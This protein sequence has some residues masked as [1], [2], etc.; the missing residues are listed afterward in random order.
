MV[1]MSCNQYLMAEGRPAI[2]MILLAGGA[3]LNM[4]LDALFVLVLG[5]GVSG[6]AA[7]TVIAQGTV[8][9]YLLWFYLSGRSALIVSRDA[10]RPRCRWCGR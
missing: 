7:A 4:A 6:A 2:A 3:I 1:A 8:V 9:G 10:L 5:W